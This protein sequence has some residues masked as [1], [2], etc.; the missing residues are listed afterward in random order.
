[1]QMSCKEL[2]IYT[3]HT[4]RK[5]NKGIKGQGEGLGTLAQII[6]AQD[7]NQGDLDEIASPFIDEEKA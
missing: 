1:M 2:R 5:I 4:G 3:G 7:I 6:L